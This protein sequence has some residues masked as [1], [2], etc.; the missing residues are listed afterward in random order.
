[1]SRG[2]AA[3]LSDLQTALEKYENKAARCKKA[4]QEATDERAR[5]FYE[6]LYRYYLKLATDFRKII[7]K[8]TDASLAA[9]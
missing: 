1:M 7:A 3:V 5:E 4:A 2:V 6:V 8:L 9:K